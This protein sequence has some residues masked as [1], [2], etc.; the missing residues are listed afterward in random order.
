MIKN[1]VIV[2][3]FGDIFEE[4]FAELIGLF[5]KHGKGNLQF[6]LKQKVADGGNGDL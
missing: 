3:V 1:I 6:V 5:I 4:L 2:Y